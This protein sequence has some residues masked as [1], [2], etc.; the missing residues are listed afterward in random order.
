MLWAGILNFKFRI[1]F[2]RLGDLKKESLSKKRPSLAV[3]R[4][5]CF[6]QSQN[7]SFNPPYLSKHTLEF[8]L[9]KFEPD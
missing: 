7:I 5:F 1:V 9:T 6:L 2:W 4:L 3:D 8:V